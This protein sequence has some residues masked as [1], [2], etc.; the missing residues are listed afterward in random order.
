MEIDNSV[1]LGPFQK[2]HSCHV[3]FQEEYWTFFT[4]PSMEI[5]TKTHL[6]E[7]STMIMLL[8]TRSNVYFSTSDRV[9]FLFRRAY[10]PC[11]AERE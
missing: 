6:L 9:T 11:L 10:L 3:E 2:S 4:R 5:S 8:E 1:L 7:L